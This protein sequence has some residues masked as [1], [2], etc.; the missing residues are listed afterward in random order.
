MAE[1]DEAAAG[2][3][4]FDRD[5]ANAINQRIFETSLDLILVV[6]RRGTFIRVSPSAY[7]IIGYRPEEMVG[8]SARPFL[9][10]DDLD[11]TREEMR[12]ARRGREMRNFEC[13]YIH[14]DGHAVPLA[15]TGVW[16]EPEQQHFFIG[17]DISERK[18]AEEQ[19][20]RAQRMDAIGQLTG[21]MAHDFNN[22][23]GV[24]VGNLDLL[25]LNGRLSAEDR[26]LVDEAANAAM[27]G[28]D[29]IRRL[30]AFA[31][32]Q[33]LQPERVAVNRLVGDIAELLGRTLG[34]NIP[35]SLNLDDEVWDVLVDPAQ[36]EASLV[37][38]AT[39][40]RDAMPQG[41]R[42]IIT[43]G[44]RRLDEE[45]AA[46]HAEL[47]PGDYVMLEVSDSGGG[48]P[49]EVMAHIFEPFFTTKEPGKGTGLGLS[50]VFGFVKQSGGHINVYSEPGVGTTFRLYL[51]RDP[52]GRAA[53]AASEPAAATA[54]G[55]ETVLVVEDNEAVRRIVMRQ[56]ASLGYRVAAAGSAAE[57]LEVLARERITLLFSDIVMPGGMSGIELAE[58]ARARWPGLRVLL[59]SGFPE[60]R[61]RGTGYPAD[62]VRL[63]SKPYGREQLART[64]R[65]VLDRPA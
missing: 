58:A 6:D 40:A 15:W 1:P 49:P 25:R 35:I 38:L 7:K 19:L 43:T 56:L 57:A 39:N 48:I 21:G 50:M 12:R 65:E 32:R 24:I 18:A 47:A 26:E 64:L 34:E 59:T 27:M 46:A 36:L 29:L 20:R 52:A 2:A 60:A 30:L 11:N 42:L 51:P 9:H 37:N 61:L 3:S 28:A 13:R 41:G 17:R 5:A 53:A 4:A 14:R 10:P 44:N 33:P 22:L 31:R 54:G 23:L 63:L 62:G 16:S 55:D 8:R 45:Y